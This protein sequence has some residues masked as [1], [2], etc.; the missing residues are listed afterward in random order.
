M[1][2]GKQERVVPRMDRNEQH[3]RIGG[4]WEGLNLFLRY[5]PP[6]VQ[7]PGA[8]NVVLYVHGATFPSALSIAHRFD[9][10]SWRDELA[11][12]GF[13]VWGLDFHGFGAS[14][15]YPQMAEPAD[16]HPALCRA[17]DASRQIECAVRFIR[18]RHDLQR[19]SLIAHSWGTIATGVFATRCPDLVE[20]LVF[21]GPITRRESNAQAPALPAWR[22]ISLED[23]WRRFVEDV[24]A[25]EAAVLNKRHFEDWGARYLDSDPEC[26]MRSPLSVKVPNGPSQDIAAAWSGDLA[27]DPGR[28][29]APVAIVRGEW[30]SVVTDTD[31]RWLFNV[32]QA[33]PMKRDVKIGRATHLMHLEE[34]RHSLYWETLCFL[35]AP[36]SSRAERGISANE[37]RDSSPSA[38]N[39]NGH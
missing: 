29:Q 20:R 32:L 26:S 19:I 22:C 11:D 10:R 18:E 39:D 8:P 14:D 27:Y 1:C 24:P 33:S 4:P 9:G 31:A 12:A 13:H 5:L 25:H 34:N 6:T 28:I 3:C 38:R 36:L 21:F 35:Q 37:G 15:R 2:T 30:D 16:A 17:E 7:Q 23:Q